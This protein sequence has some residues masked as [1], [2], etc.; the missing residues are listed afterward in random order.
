[1]SGLTIVLL[2]AAAYRTAVAAETIGLAAAF[3]NLFRQFN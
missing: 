1:L 2:N 3:N